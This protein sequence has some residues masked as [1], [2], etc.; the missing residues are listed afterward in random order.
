[1]PI[2]STCGGRGT[3]GKCRVRVVAGPRRAHARRLPPRERGARRGLAAVVPVRG[4]RGHGGRR[5]ASDDGAQ[6]GDDGRRAVRA[7]RAER[8]E[9]PAHPRGADDRGPSQPPAPGHRRAGGGGARGDACRERA[10]TPGRRDRRR[11]RSVVTATVVGDRLVDVEA[12]DT[13]GRL[14]RRLDRRR[15]HDGGR[16]TDGSRG[17]RRRR[18]GIDDQPAGALRCRRARARW[19]TPDARA[20]GPASNCATPSSARS[21]GLLGSVCATAGIAREDVLRGRG[22]RQRDDAAPAARRRPRSIGLSPFIAT[23][24]EAQDLRAADAGIAIHP[25][26][27]LVLFPSIG[28][29]VGADIVADIVATGIARERS[30]AVAGRRGHERRD[31]GR[32]RGHASS[33]RRRRRARRSRAARSCTACAPR[34][35]RSRVWSSTSPRTTEKPRCDCR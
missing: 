22:R 12:G 7:A 26:G 1:M 18:R 9:A 17:R 31:R 15:H 25:E 13:T 11:G 16:H 3:C 10:A 35:A 19:A 2:E 21:N 5:A 23:F 32:Q 14:V 30:H 24:L 29:Y 33:P 34:K 28:A 6:G 20:R 8:D 4:R 27:R